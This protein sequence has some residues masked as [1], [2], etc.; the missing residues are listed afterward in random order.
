MAGDFNFS[1]MQWDLSADYCDDSH[2]ERLLRTLI[3]EHHLVHV[4]AQPTRGKSI[5]DLM[6]VLE[7]LTVNSIEYLPRLPGLIMR[8]RC[9][10]YFFPVSSLVLRFAIASIIPA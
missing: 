9:F 2:C 10:I 8:P 7:M 4:D 5:L 1:S 3:S 6:L